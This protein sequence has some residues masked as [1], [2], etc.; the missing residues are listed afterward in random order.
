MGD[1]SK[2]GVMDTLRQA[3][4]DFPKFSSRMEL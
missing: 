4:Q 1:D 3:Q 2:R